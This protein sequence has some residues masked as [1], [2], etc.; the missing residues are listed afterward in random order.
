M[1]FSDFYDLFNLLKIEKYAMWLDGEDLRLSFP[2]GKRSNDIISSLKRNKSSIMGFLELNKIYSHQDFD[3]VNI[4]SRGSNDDFNISFAQER[5]LFMQEIQ[6]NADA[7][8]I[9]Y[10]VELNKET[11][12]QILLDSINKVAERHPVL[13]SIYVENSEGETRN[14]KRNSHLTYVYS[15]VETYDKLLTEV[16]NNIHMPFQLNEEAP[17]RLCR[18]DLKDNRYLLIMP[19][20]IA[21]DGWSTSLFFNEVS[22]LYFEISQGVP[23]E[24]PDLSI[25]YGDYAEWQRDCVTSDTSQ[26][27]LDYWIGQLN[28]VENLTLP[29][30]FPRTNETSYQGMNYDIELN[31]ELSERLRSIARE[32]ETTLYT[33]MLS[34]FFFMLQR[35]TN[36]QDIVI[37]TPSDNR[38]HTQTQALIGFFVNS[39]A[40]R[41]DVDQNLTINNLIKRVHECVVSAKSHQD[42]PFENILSELTIERDLSRHPIFQVMFSVQS[43]S[44]HSVCSNEL[45]SS[46]GLEK[47]LYQPAKYD[48]SLFVDD[49][50]S[51]LKLQWNYARSLYDESTIASY[52]ELY[53]LVLGYFAKGQE[54]NLKDIEAIT[55]KD[56][57]L[58]LHDWNQTDSP[59]PEKETLVSLFEVQVATN[60]DSIALVCDGRNLTY[61]ALDNKANQLA[62]YLRSKYQDLHNKELPKE[63]LIGVYQ[64]RSFEMIIS[65]LGILKAGGAYVPISPSYPEERVHYMVEDTA[66]QMIVTQ[67][68]YVSALLDMGLDTLALVS[69]DAPEVYENSVSTIGGYST[70]ESLAYVIYT[71]GT[72]GKPKGVM[73]PHRG[74]VSL[75]CDTDFIDITEH[76]V[77]LQLSSPDFDAATFEIW[78]SLLNGA[79]LVLFGSDK[80]TDVNHI[81]VLLK[82][83]DV[84]ILW[85]TRALFDSLYTQNNNLFKNLQYLLVGGEA[86]TPH[87][88][89][90]LVNSEARPKHILNGYGPTEGTTFTTIFECEGS[91]DNYPI[92]KA[93]NTRKLYVLNADRNLVPK[94]AIGEL[95]IGGAGVAKGYLN[96]QALTEERFLL[97]PFAT[98]DDVSKGYTHFYKTGDLVRWRDKGLLEYCGRN[99]SQVKIRGYR[100]EL[101]EIESVLNEME[102][103]SQSTVICQQHNNNQYLVAYV[104]RHD[105]SEFVLEC[106]ALRSELLKSLPEYMVPTIFKELDNFPL[107]VNGKL[108]RNALPY[109]ELLNINNY[110]APTTKTEIALCEVWQDILELE[111][112]GI[113]DN[114]FRVGGNSIKAM[115]LI[116]KINSTLGISIPLAK[117]FDNPNI[118]GILDGV[119]DYQDTVIPNN[120]D[121]ESY[122][123]SY[124]QERMLF[125]QEIQSNADA[126]HIPYLVELNKETDDQILLDSINKVAERH[127]VLN[128]IYVENSEGETRNIKRNSHLT[129]VYSKVETYDKLL[130]EVSNNIHMPFQLNEEAPLR[131]CRYDLKDN[132]YLLIMPHHIAFDGWSTSLFFNEVSCLYFETSQGVPAELPDLSISY[133]DYAEWQR[134]YVTSDTSQNQLD[135][136]IGQLNNV[137]NLT[138]PTTFPRTNETSYQGMNYDI[139][140]NSE[141]SERLRSIARENETTLYTVMLSAFFFMLQRLTNQ[142]DI[143]IGTPSDN[144]HHTQTQALIGFFVNSLALRIDVDQNLT[145]NNLIKRVHECVVSAKSH[146]DIPFENILSELTIER[147][148]SRH[149][150]FQVMFSVQS[151]ST[152]SVCSNGLF[153]SVGLEKELYQPA[154]YDLSLFVDDGESAL[155]LQWNYA[156]SLYDESTIASYAELYMLVLGYF[157]KGQE[158]NLKDI[159][160]ITDKDRELLLHDWNQT[161]SPYPEKETLVSL[162]EVQVATNPDSIALV[163]DGRNLTYR[164]LDN[165]ANQLA[166]YLRSK[167]Q[168]LYNKELPKES[169]IGVYQDRSFEMIISI[170]GIL[171]AG[172]AYVPISP[173]YPEERVHYMVEDTALQMIVTQSH[174]VSALLDMGLDTLALVSSDAPEVY[175]N[176]VSTIGGYSTPESLAYVIYTSGTTGKPKGVMIR[177]QSVVNYHHSLSNHLP[178]GLGIT[179][180]STN[181]CFDLSLTTSLCPLLS[182]GVVCVYSGEI[183]DITEYQRHLVENKIETIKMAPS[184]ASTMLL[185]FKESI[186]QIIVGGEKLEMHHINTISG[187]TNTIIDEFGPTE[188]TVGSLYSL[189]FDN[190]FK[191]IGKSY[192][193]T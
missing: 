155:K 91:H 42:I 124:S 82:E 26:N 159:E 106:D 190:K 52:A 172:G 31:S 62:H 145:I 69:S 148:L 43:F 16:S 71:S 88:V 60:P 191:G 46:V 109:V 147:D 1:K 55:D 95:Y 97:N 158:C 94:G 114:F 179:D 157:A 150:I 152:H 166:H 182:G 108:D 8:H 181:I 99:D 122:K 193:N 156:R 135:Y 48:L 78:G 127:P 120:V 137:E 59:Y 47:E 79:K 7:Y 121:K 138:L 96:K 75:V 56:R 100:I 154:K 169:L 133:G 5:M 165:K 115:E 51:A 175:E 21:F 167:Y 187:A 92:G 6:S 57:E 126:Y 36:Q 13:N 162:F 168:D 177:H 117:F 192:T 111:R 104:I 129:Y 25:S 14:I 40:L 15:K 123:V 2:D 22:C 32:N 119:S 113:T 107:T 67:S 142:Q 27:Q 50:E 143:V 136:W 140:L 151:F 53:M 93:I 19:H 105:N 29:T 35:L 9:P 118:L 86:L 189:V 61:R 81:D 74:V 164:A 37:G 54:C 45:F 58:L 139:E 110:V 103:I 116:G 141:L 18:Y 125:M 178:N 130:T 128:S 89:N 170:L 23:A 84:S 49:G 184:M 11:D 87:L 70:P 44:T 72:T 112:V 83:N 77:F 3:N 34:A 171:K 188:T 134:D 163:C 65:I 12:D 153:S 176:S 64:D 10:L 183:E 80:L 33:V 186:A 76:D 173:S 63:S 39:L 144:R 4:L 30:T 28:N 41:I 66:L 180:F 73:T 101:S 102:F 85:L 24:L 17:L 132:R 174:Y 131:L 68:H 149:P 98:K 90:K 161:D 185:D 146:Q 38:H 160:A 20:H